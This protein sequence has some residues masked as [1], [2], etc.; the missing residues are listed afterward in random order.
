MIQGFFDLILDIIYNI[1][2]SPFDELI[3]F[4]KNRITSEFIILI[5]VLILF[6]ILRGDKNLFSYKNIF[7]NDNN[8]Y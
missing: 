8:I 1:I 2:Y 6:M 7:S 3:H 5:F 4:Y